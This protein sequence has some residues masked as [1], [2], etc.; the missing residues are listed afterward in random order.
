[1][2]QRQE[3]FTGR[4]YDIITLGDEFRTNAIGC[5]IAKDMPGFSDVDLDE[6]MHR[7]FDASSPVSI[8]DSQKFVTISF[9]A[10]DRL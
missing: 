4:G 3:R 10:R 1:M 7:F 6:R 9:G 5:L 8:R 2:F